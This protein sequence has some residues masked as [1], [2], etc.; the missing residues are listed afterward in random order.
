MKCA[1]KDLMVREEK[2]ASQNMVLEALGAGTQDEKKVRN[3][4]SIILCQS[5]LFC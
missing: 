5:L 4:L 1:L 3:S 2:V